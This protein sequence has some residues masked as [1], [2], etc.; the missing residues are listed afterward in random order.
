MTITVRDVSLAIHPIT[1]DELGAVLEVYR[2]CEDFLALGPV[3]VA[4]MEMVEQDIAISEGY[5]GRFC[6]IYAVEGKMIGIVDYVP[7]NFEG[8]PS[9]AYLSLLMIGAPF[10]GQGVG[11]AVVEAVE[12]HIRRDPGVRY[13][14]AGV[15]VNNPAAVRFWQR[16]GY[17]ITGG[18]ELLPD[19]TTVYHLRKD[20]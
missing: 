1:R 9:A 5:G 15:Q 17:C 18:P 19:Q 7:A 8:E 14:L 3:P 20:V 16:N 10:R 13:I 4:S 2:Q 11:R 12:A 6:G